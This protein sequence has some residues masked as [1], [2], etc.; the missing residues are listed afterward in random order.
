M[1]D[2]DLYYRKR[3]EEELAAANCAAHVSISN[4]HREMA[5]RY[6]DMLETRLTS[7]GGEPGRTKPLGGKFAEAGPIPG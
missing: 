6:R 7:I 3:I 4:I 5:E 2:N 1:T